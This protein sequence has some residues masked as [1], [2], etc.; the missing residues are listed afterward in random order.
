MFPDKFICV[1][2]CFVSKVLTSG[3][4]DGKG[5]GKD[6]ALLLGHLKMI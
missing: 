6:P 1:V 2:V 5:M 4:I 3:F